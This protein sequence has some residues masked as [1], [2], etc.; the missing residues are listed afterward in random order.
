M[1]EQK[2]GLDMKFIEFE[3]HDGD[4]VYINPDYVRMVYAD[5]FH[6]GCCV[7]SMRGAYVS[8]KGEPVAVCNKLVRG[9]SV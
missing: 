5:K 4:K 2:W 6:E 3:E 9:Y 7:I 1:T 8:V